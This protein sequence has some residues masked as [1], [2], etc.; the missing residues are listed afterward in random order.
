MYKVLK[1]YDWRNQILFLIKKINSKSICQA[2]L[3][4]GDKALNKKKKVP[5]L[6]N[7][8]SHWKHGSREGGK[9]RKTKK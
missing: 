7:L 9:N 6:W 2:V 8:H 3:S 1:V 4:T 5:L